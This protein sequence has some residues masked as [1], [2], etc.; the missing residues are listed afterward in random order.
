MVSGIGGVSV[1]EI[2]SGGASLQRTQQVLWTRVEGGEGFN[3]PTAVDEEKGEEGDEFAIIV[4]AILRVWLRVMRN[5]SWAYVFVA[6]E[7]PECNCQEQPRFPSLM[8]EFV[9]AGA[10]TSYE[11]KGKGIPRIQL[12]F[13]RGWRFE[14]N[15][16]NLS[17][18]SVE[19]KTIRGLF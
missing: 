2:N 18:S 17:S 15:L 1:G 9:W 5:N 4:L 19:D 13:L 3:P 10:V 12:V 14:R 7:A 11:G 8:G 16:F 6:S